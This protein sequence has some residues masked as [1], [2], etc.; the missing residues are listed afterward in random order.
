M[1]YIS[2]VEE[3]Y[4]VLFSSFYFY[5]N[6]FVDLDDF[7][8]DEEGSWVFFSVVFDE[9]GSSVIIVIFGDEEMRGFGE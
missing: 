6:G 9:D 7:S 8:L 5:V 4:L 3:I 2:G 1:V